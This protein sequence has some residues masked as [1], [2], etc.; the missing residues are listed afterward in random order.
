MLDVS[1]YPAPYNRAIDIAGRW[2]FAIPQRRG[3]VERWQPMQRVILPFIAGFLA[4][5]F[6]REPSLALLQ[7]A[8]MTTIAAYST[9]PMP[10][11]ALPE[12][13]MTAVGGA[14]WGIVLAWLLRV[15]P[16]RAAPW[17]GALLFGGVV[18]TAFNIFVLGPITGRWPSGNIL[19]QVALGF[20]VNAMWGWGGLVFMRAF[21][22]DSEV[23][24]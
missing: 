6:F 11:L 18:L 19:P 12:F 16:D 24:A 8:H 2:R 17:L 21:M 7:A 23:D 22:T 9:A 1:A 10:P 4:V 3:L 5:I 20:A 15:E 14:V 13:I